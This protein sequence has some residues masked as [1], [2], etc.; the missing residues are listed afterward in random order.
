[1]NSHRHTAYLATALAVLI[2]I[3]TLHSGPSL[4]VTDPAMAAKAPIPSGAE[5]DFIR[6][7]RSLIMETPKLAPQYVNAGMSCSACHIDG[8]TKPQ[9]GSL[10]GVYAKFPQ[11][12]KRAKRFITLQD[13]LQECFLY[14][15]NGY[16]PPP[17][18]R[19]IIAMTAYIAFLS[20]GAEVGKGFPNQGFVTLH[21]SKPSDKRA[22]ARIYSARC[23]ACHGANGAGNPAANFPPLWGAK[24]FNDGAGMNTKMGAFVKANMPLNAPGSLTDQE[25]ADVSAFVLSHPRPH[26][27]PHRV[28]SFPPKPAGF[29]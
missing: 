3:I 22:G 17:N 12:N 16:A 27:D 25:A 5:V 11:W 23:A 29:F 6:Y 13:R 20:R 18:S 8:G 26:F 1:M 21:A 28:V 15:M 4:A 7:G 24:S 19:E 10:L 9:G 2:A 14:S